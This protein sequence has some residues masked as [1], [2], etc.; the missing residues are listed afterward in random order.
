MKSY[1]E[2]QL[3]EAMER[4]HAR[5]LSFD[6]LKEICDDADREEKLD[7]MLEQAE[8]DRKRRS[9]WQPFVSVGITFDKR[10]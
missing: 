4:Y 7:R 9:G 1:R 3:D 5:D 8:R 10:R 6:E 2:Q